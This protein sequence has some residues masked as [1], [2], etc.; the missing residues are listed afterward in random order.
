MFWLHLII[1]SV[2]SFCISLLLLTL[3][4]LLFFGVL[5]LPEYNQESNYA[6]LLSLSLNHL[7]LPSLLITFSI[8]GVSLLAHRRAY[9]ALNSELPIRK[10]HKTCFSI[11][12]EKDDAI[13][14]CIQALRELPGGCKD[15]SSDSDQIIAITNK[16]IKNSKKGENII[17]SIKKA[18]EQSVTI[19]ITSFSNHLLYMLDLGKNI[20]NIN[21]IKNKIVSLSEE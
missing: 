15:I 8:S 6:N 14:Y 19:E 13:S 12:T 10:E 3:I 4:S 17:L 18:P 9:K 1:L 16:H 7:I 5:V 2:L 21:F 20:E 11:P